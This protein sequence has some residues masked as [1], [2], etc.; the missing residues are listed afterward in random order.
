MRNF[1]AIAAALG[2]LTASVGGFAAAQT[3]SANDAET[4]AGT[5]AEAAGDVACLWS[6]LDPFFRLRLQV[7]SRWRSENPAE[8]VLRAPPDVVNRLS[9]A[10]GFP[11]N[12]P[13]M[14]LVTQY[15]AARAATPGLLADLKAAGLKPAGLDRA[16]DQYAPADARRALAVEIMDRDGGAAAGRAIRAAMIQVGLEQG[17]D[18]VTTGAPATLAQY[19]ATRILIDGLEAGAP[20]RPLE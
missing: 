13:M 5:S 19:F 6:R 17:D 1:R 16:L 8:L 4:S 18:G 2:L 10:C 15:W 20:P 7:A 3:D 9:L 11:P 14:G 12:T